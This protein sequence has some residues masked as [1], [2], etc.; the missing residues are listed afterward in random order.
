MF[1]YTRNVASR[2]GAYTKMPSVIANASAKKKNKK[3]VVVQVR[4]MSSPEM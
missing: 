3:V 4:I 2:L 1:V